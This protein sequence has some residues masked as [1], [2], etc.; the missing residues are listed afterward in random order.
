MEKSQ[1]ALEGKDEEDNNNNNNSVPK[2]LHQG[3][4]AG[5]LAA[6]ENAQ[7]ALGGKDEAENNNSVP[8]ALHQDGETGSPTR[9]S[10]QGD[11]EFQTDDEKSAPAA[12]MSSLQI[13]VLTL[14]L[15]VSPRATA[16][17]NRI[18]LR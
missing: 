9:A 1:T 8:K 13:V 15:C 5:D 10:I 11:D 17:W 7:P 16:F 12:R 14:A 3:G 18:S 4:E 2:D 6:M